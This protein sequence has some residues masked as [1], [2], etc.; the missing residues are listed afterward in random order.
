MIKEAI[1]QGKIPLLKSFKK[2]TTPEA[3]QKRIAVEHKQRE[4]FEK[5]EG[6]QSMNSLI[7]SIQNKATERQGRLDSIIKSIEQKQGNKSRKKRSNM[8][9]DPD[10]PSEEEFA[11]LQEKLFKR[12]KNKEALTNNVV[13]SLMFLKVLKWIFI[14]LITSYL[15]ATNTPTSTLKSLSENPPEFYSP[16]FYP[17]G[18]FLQL[19]AGTMHYWMFGNKNGSRVVLVHGIS[20]GS[21]CYDKL[22][23]EL[24]ESGHHV[25]VYDL[26]GRGYS[27]APHTFYDESLYTSQL[28]LL[29]HKVGWEK[30]SVVG[31][32]LGGGIATSFTAFYPEMVDKLVLIAPTGFMEPEDMPL[33]SKVVRLP[34]ISHFLINQPLAKPLII[35]YVKRFSK[36]AR[37]ANA[38]MEEGAAEIAQRIAKI[39]LYQFANH[40][41]F[42]KAFLRTVIDFPF[43]GLKER[44]QRV[45]Q[46]KENGST[47]VV[48][49]D[50]DKTVPFKNHV[51]L[52]LLLPNAKLSVFKNHGHDVL[53]TSWKSVNREIKSFLA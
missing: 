6:R 16:E 47:L 51:Q 15:L 45:G 34:I 46:L 43:T 30:A 53:I 38:D 42:F 44:F 11:K 32:S 10:L 21:S 13:P 18:T 28:A 8:S 27:D 7:E 49:G 40:P 35:M 4:E 52:Q 37:F 3:H 41:G 23:R 33:I 48:W 17:N 2:S 5:T 24:A 22:A 19:P 39:A 1:D 9:M 36:S 26:Y 14:G 12:S 50:Q 31:V 25:L 29:L 20:T